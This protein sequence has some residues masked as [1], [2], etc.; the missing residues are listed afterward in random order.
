MDR[1]LKKC[2]DCDGFGCKKCNNTGE[3]EYK[4]NEK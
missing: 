2:P 4:E 1:K 3:V